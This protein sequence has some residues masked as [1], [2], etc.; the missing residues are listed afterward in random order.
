[1]H[2][3][4]H[5]ARRLTL[6]WSGPPPPAASIGGLCKTLAQNMLAALSNCLLKI[7]QWRQDIK[8]PRRSHIGRK[9]ACIFGSGPGL[10]GTIRCRDSQLDGFERL[11]GH[12]F[13]IIPRHSERF[14]TTGFATR[15]QASGL[16]SCVHPFPLRLFHRSKSVR[17]QLRYCKCRKTSRHL[18]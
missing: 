4:V 17:R 10:S 9:M 12:S 15:F 3:A 14:T 8:S 5:A 18:L 16:Q 1:M 7:E 11:V 13:L 6:P 2:P